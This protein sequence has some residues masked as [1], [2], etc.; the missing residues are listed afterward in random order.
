MKKISLLVFI[1]SM[2]LVVITLTTITVYFGLWQSHKL[3]FN[4][5]QVEVVD[6]AQ[7]ALQSGSA[8]AQIIPRLPANGSA[9]VA[10]M[11]DVRKSLA[12]FVM[13]LDKEGRALESNT[14]YDGRFITVP[15]EMLESARAKG[16][17]RTTWRP[18]ASTKIALVL[19]PISDTSEWFVASGRN[20]REVESRTHILGLYIAS[21]W[22]MS[23]VVLSV[24][25]YCS[26]RVLIK[27][28]E[29]D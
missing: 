2:S 29:A 14:T 17:Y 23:V 9:T 15:A 18:D 4:D 22:F 28:S 24:F 13:V 7:Q 1:W 8:P 16:E 19:R 6:S 11:P 26:H 3:A 12:P 5:Q 20:M 27:Y 21:I 10:S 25:A